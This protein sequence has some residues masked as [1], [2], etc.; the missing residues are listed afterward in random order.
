MTPRPKENVRENVAK[1]L[2]RDLRI[3]RVWEGAS[4]IH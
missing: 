4:E 1:G 3:D 2:L